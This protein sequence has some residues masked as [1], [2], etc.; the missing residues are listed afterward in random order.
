MSMRRIVVHTTPSTAAEAFAALRV[1]LG[2]P[3]DLPPAV[4]RAADD[5]VR[6]G[7][8]WQRADRRDVDFVTIDPAGSM[9]LDQAMAVERAD[10][11]FVVRYAIAD[12]GAWVEPGSPLDTESWARGETLYFPDLRIPLYPATLSEGAASLLPGVDRPAL[13]WTLTLDA[14]GELTTT[15][16]E[17]A[18]VRSRARHD[19]VTVQAA[20]AAGTAEPWVSVLAE[21]GALR[22][23]VQRANGGADMRVPEQEVDID[24]A[25]A[26][27]L[28]YRAGLPL[29]DWN[30]QISMLT[31]IAAA[32]LMTHAR[33][34]LLRTLPAPDPRSVAHFRRTAAALGVDWPVADTYADVLARLDPHDP[35]Q[36][37]LLNQAPPLFRGAGYRAF[38]GAPPA[39]A[40][41]AGIGADYAHATAPLRRLADRYVGDLCVALCAG[42]PVPAPVREALPKLPEAMG[43]SGR[44][45][46]AADQAVVDLVEALLLATRVGESFDAVVVDSDDHSSVVQLAEPAV[47]TRM[48]TPLPLGDRVRLTLT[49]ADPVART[50]TFVPA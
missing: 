4:L 6:R 45:A 47:R 30:A 38:D 32:G 11:G 22:M 21:I 33:L 41:H 25:G 17:R 9:D 46:H 2:V 23:A 7:P 48:S 18:T 28:T 43:A 20:L 40:G 10:S 1:E 14:A 34:G 37:A 35:H 31:G 24:A 16:V 13:L 29:E 49:A 15:H 12:V 42:E 26:A 36:A 50:V 5:A 19:Y 27:S 8:A 3:L 39:D 44:R